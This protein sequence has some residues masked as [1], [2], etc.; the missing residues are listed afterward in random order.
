MTRDGLKL[1]TRHWPAAEPRAAMVITHGLEEHCGRY[2]EVAERLALR[3][4][5]VFSWDLR[6]FGLSGGERAWVAEWERF[7]DDLEDRL[8]AA[9]AAVPGRPAI[10]YGHSLGGLIALGYTLAG[11]PQPDLLILS[12]PGI[13]DSLAGW[14]HA[15]G[16]LLARVAPH[17][18]IPNGISAAMTSRDPDRQRAA[19]ADPLRIGDSTARF[20]ALAFAEQARVRAMA[21]ALAVPTLVIHGLADP[22]VPPAATVPLGAQPGV[23]RRAYE[24]LRHEL[25]NEPEG[26]RVYDEVGAWIDAEL[27]RIEDARSEPPATTGPPTGPGPGEAPTRDVE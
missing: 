19:A 27:S 11:R 17:L 25:H 16:P 21:P 8:A 9:R 14:K 26:P 13:D 1:A 20:G 10:L 6:G 15:L 22:I 2:G 12:A 7:H 4:I 3:G 24:G 18:R 23:T 5:D